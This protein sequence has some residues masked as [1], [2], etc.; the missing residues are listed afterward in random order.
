[1]A[2]AKPIMEKSQ[3]DPRRRS[4]LR[5]G[6]ISH[7]GVSTA[8]GRSASRRRAN[9]DIELATVAYPGGH[10]RGAADRRYPDATTYM[11]STSTRR[12]SKSPS[13]RCGYIRPAQNRRSP[14]WSTYVRIGNSLVGED[15][16][17]GRN[18]DCRGRRT[19]SRASTGAPAFPEVWPEGAARRL[20]Y[21]AR[22]SALCEA[23]EPDEGRSGRRW[24]ICT[25]K[26]GRRHLSERA[27]R[28]LRSLS[29][30]HR[31]GSAAARAGRSHGL[32][33]AKPL[34]G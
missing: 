10:Q 15:F 17:A 5:L 4:G 25:A 30:L 24:R 31:K 8:T 27:D 19:R 2:A 14:R 3:D 6:R 16:W 26:R 1:M 23:A 7:L 12:R 13:W 22:Q 33:R 32:H 11:V 20:R 9:V 34:G 28:Q 29:A 21:R 18:Q